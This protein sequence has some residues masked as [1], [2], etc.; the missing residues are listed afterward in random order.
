MIENLDHFRPSREEAFDA[1]LALGKKLVLTNGPDD[2]IEIKA[3]D[4]VI[5]MAETTMLRAR[6]AQLEGR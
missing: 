1:F 5:L 3:G 4:L 6:I 2:V